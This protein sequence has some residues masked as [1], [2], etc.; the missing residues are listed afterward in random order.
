MKGLQGISTV[1]EAGTAD[2]S[3]L[4]D[5]IAENG[6]GAVFVESSLLV[7]NIEAL[8]EAVKARGFETRLGGY[9]YSD[10]IGDGKSGT[11]TYI[12]A[13]KHNIDTIAE[14]LNT[15]D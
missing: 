12:S 6:I 13:F 7:K 4:A 11:D 14:E 10:S 2:V 1:S 9:L 15:I 5:Y 8:I 3:R